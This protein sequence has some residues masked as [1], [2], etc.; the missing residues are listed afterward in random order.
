MKSNNES[1]Y[2][3]CSYEDIKKLHN[4]GSVGCM[5]TYFATLRF[6]HPKRR[7]AWPKN[8]T[9]AKITGLNV[10]TVNKSY[11]KLVRA[12]VLNKQKTGT[13]ESVRYSFTAKGKS[14]IRMCDESIMIIM[15]LNGTEISMY[16]KCLLYANRKS[17]D[18]YASKGEIVKRTGRSLSGVK[19][20]KRSLITK[21]ILLDTGRVI[22]T[23]IRR[24]AHVYHIKGLYFTKKN[25][26]RETRN[27]KL[28]GHSATDRRKRKEDYYL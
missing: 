22:E 19:K 18:M 4:L 21:G 12:G 5:R 6:L 28:G 15:C 17:G 7:D 8:G 1:L 14:Y 3:D 25:G 13:Y 2:Y 26:S 27:V 9:V 20:A 10:T 16:L 11:A 24:G 23:G